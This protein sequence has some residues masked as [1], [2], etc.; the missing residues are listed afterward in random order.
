VRDVF[1]AFIV[2][3]IIAYILARPVSMLC[4]H[5]HMNRTLAI[6]LVYLLVVG[7]LGFAVWRGWGVLADQATNLFQSREAIITNLIQQ[8]SAATGW[9]PD[10]AAVTTQVL[11]KVRTFIAS[12]PYE[13]LAVGGALSRSALFLV[14]TLISSI[15]FLRDGHTFGAFC[16]RPIPDDKHAEIISVGK[17]IDQKFSRYLNGQL[18]LMACMAVLVYMILIFWQIKFAVIVAIVAGVL[19]LVP[20]FGPITAFA[21]ATAITASQVGLHGALPVAALLFACRM[22]QDYVVIPKVIGHAVQL[23]P[24]ITLFAVMAGDQLDGGLGMLLSV[25]AA[26]ALSVI[27]NH[28]YPPAVVAQSNAGGKP[29]TWAPA[30]AA[31]SDLRQLLLRLGQ[32]IK[33]LGGK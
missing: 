14:I 22:F 9:N 7:G 29:K 1:P 24:L 23:H 13:L 32:S 4:K 26:A 25:P 30:R 21:M 18:V 12:Q 11:E 31:A 27:W 10:I 33:S 3:T 6:V 8:I 2:G 19:E 5:L 28:F 15:Y 17:E 20:L 16:L